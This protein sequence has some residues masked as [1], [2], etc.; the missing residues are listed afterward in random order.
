MQGDKKYMEQLTNMPIWAQILSMGS[1]MFASGVL[2]TRIPLA[3]AIILSFFYLYGVFAKTNIAPS[4][5]LQQPWKWTIIHGGVLALFVLLGIVL[6]VALVFSKDKDGMGTGMFGAYGLA[7]IGVIFGLL[8]LVSLIPAS[9]KWVH[10]LKALPGNMWQTLLW[11]VLFGLGIVTGIGSVF[12][13]DIVRQIIGPA[14]LAIVVCVC[15]LYAIASGHNQQGIIMSSVSGVLVL[16]MIYQGMIRTI[17]I[18]M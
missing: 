4:Y 16:A 5:L 3:P 14:V 7:G 18:L 8:V 6:F 2:M 17:L 9:I 13:N 12:G 11:C 10:L 15:S 1:F